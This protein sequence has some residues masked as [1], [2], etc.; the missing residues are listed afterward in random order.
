MEVTLPFALVQSH[1]FAQDEVSWSLFDEAVEKQCED[2]R[3]LKNTGGTPTVAHGEEGS[4]NPPIL[5]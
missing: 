4:W 3:A 5:G 2:N 1:G